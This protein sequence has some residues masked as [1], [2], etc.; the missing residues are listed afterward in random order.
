MSGPITAISRSLSN[1]LARVVVTGLN[2][3]AKCQ[4][5]Q[6]GLM[7]GETKENIE[8]L[9]PYGFT[10]AP[11]LGAEGIAVFPDGDRSHGV[12]IV[13][14]DRR[15]RIKGLAAGEVAVYTD[16]GDSIILKR[17]RIIEATTEQFII[18][19]STKITLDTPL[20]E[21]TGEVR[22]SISTMS[23]MRGTF[24]GHT[25]SENGDSGGTTDAP[26]QKMGSTS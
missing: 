15:Y 16:E 10:A 21:G 8:H 19:A 22:D 17:G 13:V 2:A 3:A 26:T 23:A 1:M 24:N 5:L 11:H 25:H 12:I 9:E 6:V 4:M 20:V 18:H 7:A 14:A